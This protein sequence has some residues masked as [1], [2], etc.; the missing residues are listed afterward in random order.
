MAISCQIMA[1]YI[2]KYVLLM[3]MNSENKV[4]Q[5]YFELKEDKLYFNQIK[6]YTNLSNSSLQNI[7]KRLINNNI[8]EVNK[9]KSNT[10]YK[11][12]D[13]KVF[14][15]K[16]IEIALEKF[17]NLNRGVRIPLQN[18]LE[19]IPKDIFTIVLFGSASKKRERKDSDID[20]LIVSNIKHDLTKIKKEVESISNNP[21]NLF[22]CNID[23]FIQSEDHIII[24][25]RETGF[26]IK[27]EQNYYEVVLDEY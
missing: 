21:L 10:F 19:Q 27:G 18:F 13:K 20:I 6:E 22:V 9:T 24:Q 14:T 7:L 11:I 26:P 5:A 23:E 17:N 25:A 4:F 16:F 8:I 1:K 15:V 2:N 12:R 3:H